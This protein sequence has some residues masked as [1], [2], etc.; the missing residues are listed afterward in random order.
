MIMEAIIIIKLEFESFTIEDA[1]V[2]TT[3]RQ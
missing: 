2:V 3:T 1:I